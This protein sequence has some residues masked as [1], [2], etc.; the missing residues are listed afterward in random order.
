VLNTVW[1]VLSGDFDDDHRLCP[2]VNRASKRLELITRH[3]PLWTVAGYARS[4]P[5]VY[6]AYRPVSERSGSRLT[7]GIPRKRALALTEMYRSESRPIFCRAERQSDCGMS[8]MIFI[9]SSVRGQVE[10]V[11]ELPPEL[12]NTIYEPRRDERRP[13][14][15]R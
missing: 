1:I 8:H 4:R 12:F 3:Q 13:R 11:R 5:S 2:A 6:V 9:R 10:N 14:I 7:G 15:S